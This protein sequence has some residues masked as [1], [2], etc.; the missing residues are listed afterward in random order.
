MDQPKDDI[1]KHLN[2]TAMDEVGGFKEPEAPAV[3]QAADACSSRHLHPKWAT[4][5]VVCM[6][7]R[8]RIA[9]VKRSIKTKSS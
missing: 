8:K 6:P 2:A 9:Q 1:S 7:N 4:W 3:G 5:C